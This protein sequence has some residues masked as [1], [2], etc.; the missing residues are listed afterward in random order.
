MYA[1]MGATGNIGSVIVE[2][3][4]ADRERVRVVARDRAR[5][6]ALAA[7]GAEIAVADVND[8]DA[9]ASAF[10]GVKGAY[11]LVPPHF[12]TTDFHRE[13]AD[14]AARV[15]RAVSDARVPHVVA[16]SSVG[17]HRSAGTGAVLSLH[18]FEASL[19]GAGRPL[20]ILRPAYFMQ[21]WGSVLPL[22]RAEGI[23]PTMTTPVDTR[24]P[25]VST[26][27]IGRIAARALREPVEGERIVHL[28][29][30]EDYSPAD[31]AATAARILGKPVHSV[32]PPHEEWHAI[33][34]GAGMSASY[35]SALVDLY[36]GIAA[37]RLGAEPG[38]PVE[39]GTVTLE[40][41][42]RKLLG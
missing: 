32:V 42:F 9:L 11:V 4:L 10:A 7:R 41:A 39:R 36:D 24:F 29:G 8:A 31:A 15:A 6:S 5:V 37:G 27:D 16:L 17:A 30:P 34:V 19:R 28:F 38:I 20:T 22:A 33:L 23:L 3:L 21:N 40:A 18:G 35:A 12:A 25:M 26:D 1:V 14:V 2:R 13:S